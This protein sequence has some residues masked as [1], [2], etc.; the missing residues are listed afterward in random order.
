MARPAGLEPATH[1]L[2]EVGFF[3]DI[4][5][6]VALEA[7]GVAHRRTLYDRSATDQIR[8]GTGHLEPRT[9]ETMPYRDDRRWCELVNHR[10]GAKADVTPVHCSAGGPRIIGHNGSGTLLSLYTEGSHVDRSGDSKTGNAIIKDPAAPIRQ[11][12]TIGISLLQS[13][14]HVLGWELQDIITQQAGALGY[15]D[16]HGGGRARKVICNRGYGLSMPIRPCDGCMC[17]V[18]LVDMG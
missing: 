15:G 5:G 16:L 17:Q 12:R 4:N 13:E 10:R 9:V 1:S 18:F 6:V 11:K 7:H 14:E 3:N 2:E 8:R